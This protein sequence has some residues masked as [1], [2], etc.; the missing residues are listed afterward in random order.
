MVGERVREELRSRA[1]PRVELDDVL[2][3]AL[4]DLIESEVHYSPVVD[5]NGCVAGV[6]SLEVISQ[7]LQIPPEQVRTGPDLVGPGDEE[8]AGAEGSPR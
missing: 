5:A 7:T 4:A 2:R 8:V 1:E 3:D 6:L